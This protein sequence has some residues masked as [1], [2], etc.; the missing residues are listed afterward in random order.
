MEELEF[1][2]VN[3]KT[4]QRLVKRTIIAFMLFVFMF[5]LLFCFYNKSKNKDISY[6]E[7]GRVDYTVDLSENEFFENNTLASNNQYISSLIDTINIKFK[8]NIKM[9]QDFTNYS[10]RYRIE[11]N[12]NVTDKTTKN[13]IYDFNTVLKEEEIVKAEENKFAIDSSVAIDYKKYDT[14][15]K[16]LV[17]TYN[18]DNADCK[19][20]VKLF[21]D[22]LD[23]DNNVK[24]GTTMVVNIPLNVKTVN[25][26]VENNA[27]SDEAK[28][29]IAGDKNENAWYLMALAIILLIINMDNIRKIITDLKRSCPQELVYDMKL[30]EI[31]KKY[32]PYIQKVNS[33]FDINKY[34]LMRLDSFNDLLE[35]RE[36]TQNPIL[37]LENEDG[38]HIFFFI[39]TL[40]EILYVYELNR[41]DVKALGTS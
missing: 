3:D 14:L 1:G 18:L 41:N 24:N 35:I 11:A 37:M 9:E 12:T 36:M 8:Y 19:I 2:S 7:N 20:A 31:L 17:S 22:L 32:R 23:K 16:K 15:I 13:N 4:R 30:R 29:F 6:R 40:T 10:Y 38:T 33:E 5:I 21:V 34:S 25:I 39:T 27:E 28:I 26:D